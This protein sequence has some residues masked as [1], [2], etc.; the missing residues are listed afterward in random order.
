M[1]RLSALLYAFSVCIFQFAL[2]PIPVKRKDHLCNFKTQW[3]DNAAMAFMIGI[4]GVT[5]SEVAYPAGLVAFGRGARKQ[6][7][8]M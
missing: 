3:D 4:P 7:V 1:V 8:R 2:A 6:K 5:S